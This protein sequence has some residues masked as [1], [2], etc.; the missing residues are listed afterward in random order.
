MSAHET[1]KTIVTVALATILATAPL[2]PGRS[3]QA[4]RF[5]N[6]SSWLQNPI[7]W[8]A[9]ALGLETSQ[10]PTPAP[11]GPATSS[12]APSDGRGF[13]VDPNGSESE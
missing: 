7:T 2:A 6:A 11:S 10:T 12:A 5:H 1:R 13:T 9:A 4:G 8:V 3:R